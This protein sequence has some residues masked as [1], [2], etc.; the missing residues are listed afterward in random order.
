[1]YR[2]CYVLN[3]ISLYRA[4]VPNLWVMTHDPNLGHEPIYK[5][6][7]NNIYIQYII[8]YIIRLRLSLIIQK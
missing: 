1:M 5:N 4:V 6:I 8:I 3:V 7:Y 2:L